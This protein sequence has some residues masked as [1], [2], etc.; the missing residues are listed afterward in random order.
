MSDLKGSWALVLGASSGFGEA[1]SL[2]L[3]R[4]GMNICGV[5]LD[6]KQT[7]PN[8]DRITGE[9]RKAGGE[10]LFFNGNAADDAK[11]KEVLDS[12][13]GK[14][15]T[16]RILMHS[17]AFG[18]LKPFLT[19]KPEDAINKAQMDMTLDVMAN[20]LVYWVQDLW[21]RKMLSKGSRIVAM[22]SAGSTR[23]WA[24]YGAVSAAKSA[25]E[26]H[27]RQLAFELAPYGVAANAIRAGVT[28][29]PALRKIPGNEKMIEGTLARHPA[30]RLTTPHD[31]ACTIAALA[32]SDL[33]WVSGNTIGVDGGEIL[34]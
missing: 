26:S 19:E 11:R 20:S 18:T 4:R 14:A 23:I 27:I 29:T 24:S 34:I 25:L 3:A 31:V 30:K 28:D 12:L 7:L 9:I 6:R 22:T 21:Q 5:H 15:K 1:T 8:V 32:A 16:V 33:D 10:A 13:A 17:L 2:E